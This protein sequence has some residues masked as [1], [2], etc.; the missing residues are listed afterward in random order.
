MGGPGAAG[1]A[2]VASKVKASTVGAG[3]GGAIAT[4]I[5]VIVLYA[6]EQAGLTLPENVSAAVSGLIVAIVSTI[7]AFAAGYQKEEKVL[8]VEGSGAPQ[9]EA[10][11]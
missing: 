9:R 11:R 8:P 2:P 10:V 3:A 7:A 6:L 5:S 4:P 1:Q